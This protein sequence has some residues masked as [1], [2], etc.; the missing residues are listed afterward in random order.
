MIAF[1]FMYAL[2]LKY[3][4]FKRYTQDLGDL[5]LLHDLIVSVAAVT[6][7]GPG[8]KQMD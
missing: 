5:V 7:N 3:K 4:S 1:I 8:T 2:Y 6:M